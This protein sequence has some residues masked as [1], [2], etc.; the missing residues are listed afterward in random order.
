MAVLLQSQYFK[1][2]TELW[3][4]RKLSPFHSHRLTF[5]GT[6]ELVCWQLQMREVEC[7]IFIVVILARIKTLV[8]CHLYYVNCKVKLCTAKQ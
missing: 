7:E 8:I 5:Q 6:F 2:V 4:C 3:L 1:E